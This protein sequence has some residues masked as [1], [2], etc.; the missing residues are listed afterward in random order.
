MNSFAKEC[1]LFITVTVISLGAIRLEVDLTQGL[2]LLLTG[3]GLII[4]R[5][6]LKHLGI[7]L[8]SR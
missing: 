1:L 6:Y 8:S 5:A 3:A 2:I 7:P 4:L